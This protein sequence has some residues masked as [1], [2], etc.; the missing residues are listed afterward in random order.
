MSNALTVSIVSHGHG[1][2]I[3]H[4]IGDLIKGIGTPFKLIITLNVAEDESFLASLDRAPFTSKVIRN[5]KPKGFGAN[6]NSAFKLCDSD[7]FLVLNPDARLINQDL[8]AVMSLLGNDSMVG[9]YGAKVVD[10]NQRLQLTAREFPTFSKSLLRFLNLN[11]ASKSP[12]HQQ[13]HDWVAGMFMLFPASAYRLVNGFDERYFMYLEDVD[14]CRRLKR[15]GLKILYNDIVE[16]VHD[17]QFA[18]RKN[19]RHF[20]WHVSS[21]LRFLWTKKG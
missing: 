19:F 2:H 11:Q 10:S 1:L 18:S 12:D 17:G 4:L 7:Y 3:T 14:I 13:P 9:V 6:H 21:L 20:F 8:S 5:S 16:I 15:R